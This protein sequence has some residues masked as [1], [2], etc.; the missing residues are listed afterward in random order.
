MSAVIMMMAIGFGVVIEQTIPAPA[1]IGFARPPVLASVAA[2]F[3]L[4]HSAPAMLSA[5]LL[6]GIISD[7]IGALPPG[8]S[9]LAFAAFGTVLYYYRHAVFS[10]KPM[11]NVFLGAVIG[12]GVP[13][14]V[15]F[16][17]LFSGR[18]PFCF[19]PG[20]F[21]LKLIG[22]TIYG[23]FFF[24]AIYFLLKKLELMTGVCPSDDISDDI[25][26]TN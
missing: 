12:A 24:P 5:A 16:F 11:T 8:G 23:A 14:I 19:Q 1:F 20:L 21:I 15:L 9:T 22:T 7:S 18:T 4:T 13:L 17:L 2:Y 26:A 3:A 6:G 25:H 10:G